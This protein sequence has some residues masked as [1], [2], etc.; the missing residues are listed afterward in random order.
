MKLFEQLRKFKKRMDETD[1]MYK[2]AVFYRRLLRHKSGFV[3]HKPN[4]FGKSFSFFS[5]KNLEIN[6]GKVV[7]LFELLIKCS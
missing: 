5:P 1:Y 2:D 3:A 4:I 6:D 7:V